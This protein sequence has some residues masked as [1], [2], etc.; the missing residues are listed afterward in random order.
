MARTGVLSDTAVKLN[1]PEFFRLDIGSQANHS[2]QFIW[3]LI[4]IKV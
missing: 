3:I 2:I 1:Y 4:I